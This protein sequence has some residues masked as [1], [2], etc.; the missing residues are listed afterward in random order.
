MPLILNSI[1]QIFFIKLGKYISSDILM[2][3]HQS[4]V[5]LSDWALAR[6]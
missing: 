2:Y 4:R 6:E 3:N 1:C 5:N